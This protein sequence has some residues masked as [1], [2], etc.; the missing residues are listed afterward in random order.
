LWRTLCFLLSPWIERYKIIRT[1]LHGG[2]DDTFNQGDAQ[3][4]NEGLAVTLLP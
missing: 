2:A 3:D 1:G 4:W